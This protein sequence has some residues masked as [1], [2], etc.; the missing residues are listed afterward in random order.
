MTSTRLKPLTRCSEKS[1]KKFSPQHGIPSSKFSSQRA[2]FQSSNR[3]PNLLSTRR[4]SSASLLQRSLAKFSS[5]YAGFPSFG[6]LSQAWKRCPTTLRQHHGRLDTSVDIGRL[7][8]G[9]FIVVFFANDGH[10]I[11]ADSHGNRLNR[12]SPLCRQPS[13]VSSLPFAVGYKVWRGCK[14]AGRCQRC[15]RKNGGRTAE[16]RRKDGRRTADERHPKPCCQALDGRQALDTSADFRRRRIKQFSP[17]FFSND[18]RVVVVYICH[19][20]VQIGQRSAADKS[21]RLPSN[22]AAFSSLSPSTLRPARL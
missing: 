7:E 22:T 18:G 9:Q 2:G 12:T 14:R 5:Q 3:S 10:F 19:R 8:N 20:F 16:E 13:T 6:L 1:I 17:V 4:I 15:R 11:I 21:L